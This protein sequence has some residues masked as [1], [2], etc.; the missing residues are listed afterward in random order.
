VRAALRPVLREHLRPA[1]KDSLGLARH[2]LARDFHQAIPP[3]QVAL[4]TRP[5]QARVARAALRPVVREHLRLAAK[6]CLGLA[7]HSAARAFHQAILPEQAG[8]ARLP[9]RQARP[10]RCSPSQ[11]QA[12]LFRS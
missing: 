7:R 6:H 11:V 9:P 2:S 4:A 1:A 12:S 8:L 5:L 10:Y 3:E